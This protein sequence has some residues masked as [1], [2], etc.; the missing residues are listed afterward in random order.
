MKNETAS[1]N[2]MFADNK[3]RMPVFNEGGLL[4]MEWLERHKGWIRTERQDRMESDAARKRDENYID[5]IYEDDSNFEDDYIANIKINRLSPYVNF[6]AGEMTKR[7]LY[8]EIFALG[9]D[10]NED[11]FALMKLRDLQSRALITAS[12]FHSQRSAAIVDA[13]S[14]GDGWV[15]YGL[16]PKPGGG[17]KIFAKHERWDRIIYDAQGVES[18][19][20]IQRC[21]FIAHFSLIDKMEFISLYPD[22]ADEAE[23]CAR[24][25]PRGDKTPLDPENGYEYFPLADSYNE[26]GEL[27]YVVYGVMFFRDPET[28]EIW[29]YPFLTD[30]GVTKMTQLAPLT[31]PY[32][33]HHYPFLRWVSAQYQQSRYPYSP[34]RHKVDIER[35]NQQLLRGIARKIGAKSTIME[36]GAIPEGLFGERKLSLGQFA[37]YI[38]NENEKAVSVT[39]VGDGA[40][41][42]GKIKT[43]DGSSEANQYANLLQIMMSFESLSGGAPHPS[44]TGGGGTHSAVALR[45]HADNAIMGQRMLFETDKEQLKI[46]G[47]MN[48]Y[49]IEDYEEHLP[50]LA[51]MDEDGE[52][53]YLRDELTQSD[54]MQMRRL[55]D[56]ITDIGVSVK[57]VERSPDMATEVLPVVLETLKGSAGNEQL[58]AITAIA[59]FKKIGWSSGLVEALTEGYL[60]AG[61]DIP[62]K[63]LS[64]RL[65]EEKKKIM[66]NREKQQ[67]KRE[68]VEDAGIQAELRKLRSESE[69]NETGADLNVAKGVEAI[70][71]AQEKVAGGGENADAMNGDISKMTIGDMIA[72]IGK[73]SED[74]KQLMADA[75]MQGQARQ[76]PPADGDVLPNAV[77]ADGAGV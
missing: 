76:P 36:E 12:E 6:V 67:A 72:L 26:M 51:F 21:K 19:G 15:R 59:A 52:Q 42:G 50:L 77:P 33:H 48:L 44:L 30:R 14:S 63:Y 39:I 60:R 46:A 57:V 9:G 71:S 27:D 75:K 55:R 8:P 29:K 61:V 69:K 34:L 62:D 17:V 53:K 7:A 22:F 38:R 40:L 2:A 47:K 54:P 74:N 32:S 73:L 13:L 68:K 70:A 16:R 10:A 56:M 1:G 23:S 45:E 5:G 66:E 11:F 24:A 20:A 37:E 43:T 49:F 64:M 58:V 41:Q 31:R 35:Y 3:M 25:A 4:D 65:R 18:T 28:R